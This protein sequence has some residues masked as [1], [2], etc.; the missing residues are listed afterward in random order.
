MSVLMLAL[1][2][3]PSNQTDGAVSTGGTDWT[4][5]PDV[6]LVTGQYL[7]L[8]PSFGS[9][10][11][12]F[13]GSALASEGGFL[14]E[15]G[16][17]LAGT[18]RT[19]GNYTVH[20]VAVTDAG[21]ITEISEC[22]VNIGVA[23][24]T[25]DKA[26]SMTYDDG[27]HVDTSDVP[28]YD[29]SY[30]GFNRVF[31]EGIEED[32]EYVIQYRSHS[33]T[34]TDTITDVTASFDSWKG[35]TITTEDL[36]K[37]GSGFD[38]AGYIRFVG[39]PEGGYDGETTVLTV[40]YLYNGTER[41]STIHLYYATSITV[42]LTVDPNGGSG[43]PDTESITTTEKN[44]YVGR[45]FKA[46][47]CSF[48]NEGYDFLGWYGNQKPYKVS[49]LTDPGDTV[50]VSPSVAGMGETL[51]AIWGHIAKLKYDANGGRMHSYMTSLREDKSLTATTDDAKTWSLP[52]KYLPTKEGYVFLGWSPDKNATVPQ[53]AYDSGTETVTPGTIDV[54]YGSTVTLYAVWG[55]TF[56]VSFYKE[57]ATEPFAVQTVA[58]GSS[59]E[60]LVDPDGAVYSYYW[61]KAHTSV[62][63]FGAVNEDTDVYVVLKATVAG[64]MT[65]A[66][67]TALGTIGVG[68]ILVAVGLF[69]H[70]M[71]AILG[72]ILSAFGGCEYL[73]V[74]GLFGRLL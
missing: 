3:P 66:D 10:A 17:I 65:A 45:I 42:T 59:A 47:Y 20:I 55:Q 15:N 19:A 41:T 32:Q 70:P 71:L 13:S 18:A 27:W 40:T 14:A 74:T 4:S 12:S 38:Y 26:V 56:T 25:A 24:G 67:I 49:N 23:V 72:L 44:G 31:Q 2:A 28:T 1:I 46:P 22:T 73:G 8:D 29:V 54:S 36:H 37:G 53:Y 62:Y 21:G 11:F 33:R 6:G 5:P 35:L 69:G 61:D 51:Y 43:T 48:T 9:T 58:G 34:Y 64:G 63:R 30:F 50:V 7:T 52:A 60:R 16:G 57:D 39:T 68:A